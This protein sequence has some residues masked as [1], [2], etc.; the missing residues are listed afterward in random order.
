MRL[1]CPIKLAL[2]RNSRYTEPHVTYVQQEHNLGA[3]MGIADSPVA[4]QAHKSARA[5]LA[6]I[7]KARGRGDQEL[8]LRSTLS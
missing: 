6:Q 4:A 2:K 5:D 1:G 8:G 3:R 7:T